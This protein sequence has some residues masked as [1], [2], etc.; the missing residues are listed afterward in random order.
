MAAALG[1]SKKTLLE[2]EKG[3]S[4]LGWMGCL[5]FCAVFR[6]SGILTAAVG[7]DPYAVS[8]A[9][10]LEGKENAAP[11]QRGLFWSVVFEEDGWCV[12]Q[13]VI[14]QHYRL[15]SPSGE[16]IASSFDFEELRAQIR[17]GKKSEPS[18]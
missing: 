10:A 1:L 16:L 4:S 9:L 8:A 11:S 18:V 3:R 15:F 12:S 13:N 2:I 6:S 5:A 7:G 17:A 14:S